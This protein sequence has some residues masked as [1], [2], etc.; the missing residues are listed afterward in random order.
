MSLKKEAVDLKES[1]LAIEV[2]EPSPEHEVD[3]VICYKRTSKNLSYLLNN[4][5]GDMT[6]RELTYEERKQLL[7]F[8]DES[9]GESVLVTRSLGWVYFIRTLRI[10]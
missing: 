8:K 2:Y 3:R 5:R 10:S 7:K 9:K 6:L 4:C 1:G